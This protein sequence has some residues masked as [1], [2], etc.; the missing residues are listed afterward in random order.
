MFRIGIVF[1]K[2]TD[3]TLPR[4][5]IELSKGILENLFVDPDDL[6]Y[7]GKL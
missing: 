6:V 2:T 1:R 3:C 4:Y 7:I 5:E